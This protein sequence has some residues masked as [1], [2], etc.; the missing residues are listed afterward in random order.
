MLTLVALRLQQFGY[1]VDFKIRSSVQLLPSVNTGSQNENICLYGAGSDRTVIGVL[2][3]YKFSDTNPMAPVS[4]D[5]N[6]TT[7]LLN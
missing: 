3:R 4:M 5:I 7:T 6:K 1:K 2:P